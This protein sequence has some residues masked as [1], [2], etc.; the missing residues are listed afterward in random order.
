MTA[1][2]SAPSGPPP[3]PCLSGQ[4]CDPFT[5]LEGRPSV[6]GGRVPRSAG[7]PVWHRALEFLMRASLLLSLA[8]AV[9][10]AV[11]E[12]TQD[13]WPG[14]GFPAPDFELPDFRGKPVRLAALRGEKVVFLNFWASWCPACRQEMPT[15]EKLYRRFGSR[16]LEIVAVSV[17]RNRADAARF[18]EKHGI[19][20][21]VLLDPDSE[22]AGEYRVGFIP[23]HYFIDRRGVI[24][25]R[26]VGGRDWTKP[27]TWEVIET[28]L[29]AGE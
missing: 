17:D 27:E 2:F 12:P 20:F 10:P 11:A 9:G 5:G 29:R 1:S 4:G 3:L 6:G 23:T 8:L 24:R 7:A 18:A 14:P 22:V 25:A 28:L 16:G 13:E 26:E 15:M 19:T 21:P